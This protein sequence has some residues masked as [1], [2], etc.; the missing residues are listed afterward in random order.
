MSIC[1][2]RVLVITV[3]YSTFK[4]GNVK[5]LPF[6]DIITIITASKSSKITR[7]VSSL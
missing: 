3:T 4:W 1:D 7:T 2:I 6:V 5:L